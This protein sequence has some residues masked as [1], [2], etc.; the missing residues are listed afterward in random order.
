MDFWEQP[1]PGSPLEQLNRSSGD[2][3]KF[4]LDRPMTGTP[5]TE[6][7]YNSGAPW[8]FF[9]PK[10]DLVVAVVA[11]NGAGLDPLY[12]GVLPALTTR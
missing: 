12:D 3:V 7:A 8:L 1:Y 6:F 5:G 11:S 10:L 9:L 4:V 2:W